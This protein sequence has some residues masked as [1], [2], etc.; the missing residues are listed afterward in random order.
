MITAANATRVVC[1]PQL[2]RKEHDME[3]SASLHHE[4]TFAGNPQSA[5][6]T[7]MDVG[8]QDWPSVT[9][10]AIHLLNPTHSIDLAANL[11]FGVISSLVLIVVCT[12]VTERVVEPRL[13]QYQGE[14]TTENGGGVAPE[15]ARG[16]RFA[17][18]M[19]SL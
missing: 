7:H 9:N 10:H 4:G 18:C 1:W 6:A 17:R 13:G 11:Y 15:E 16:L 12:V 14:V 8:P 3:R 5:S 19:H 2:S